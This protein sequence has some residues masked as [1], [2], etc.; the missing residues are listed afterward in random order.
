MKELNGIED[1]FFKL[2]QIGVGKTLC[3]KVEIS[4]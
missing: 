4:E 2:L 3:D 1:R